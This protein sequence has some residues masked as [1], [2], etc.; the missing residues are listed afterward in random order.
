MRE[1]CVSHDIDVQDYDLLD[2]SYEE[3]NDF[4]RGEASEVFERN[5]LRLTGNVLA[6]LKTVSVENNYWFEINLQKPCKVTFYYNVD[7]SKG[8]PVVKK[9]DKAIHDCPCHYEEALM[10]LLGVYGRVLDKQKQR[11]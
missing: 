7:W 10:I 9:K 11:L 5:M 4:S 3:L 2:L 6:I 8:R 1:F